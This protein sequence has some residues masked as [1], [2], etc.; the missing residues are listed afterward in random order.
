MN[1]ALPKSLEVGGVE[2][3][4]RTDYRVILDAISALNDPDLYPIEKA[5]A[6]GCSDS[7]DNYKSN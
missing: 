4:I 5:E 7:Q 6:Y 3:E 1:Y 2:Y